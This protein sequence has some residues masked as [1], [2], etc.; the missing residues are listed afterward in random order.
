MHRMVRELRDR[1]QH[2]NPKRVARLMGEAGLQGVSR[3]KSTRTTGRDGD[4]PSAPD[5]VDRDFAD[6]LR[7]RPCPAAG[8]LMR[9]LF[10][11]KRALPGPPVL[12]RPP[13]LSHRAGAPDRATAL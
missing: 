9:D 3:R 5:L 1:G 4:A 2:L 10:A 8:G 13:G 11:M 6:E 12:S 7:T